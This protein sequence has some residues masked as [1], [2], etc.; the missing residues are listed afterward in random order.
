MWCGRR[1]RRGGHSACQLRKRASCGAIV[2][3]ASRVA[4]RFVRRRCRRG[5]PR[6]SR[7]AR[8]V[9]RKLVARRPRHRR[10]LCERWAPDVS[11]AVPPLAQLMRHRMQQLLAS[12]GLAARVVCENEISG[13][14][15]ARRWHSWMH[16]RCAWPWLHSWGRVAGLQAAQFSRA[17]AGTGC[18]QGG[19]C[20]MPPAS[21]SARQ[22]LHSFTEHR[23]LRHSERRIGNLMPSCHT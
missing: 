20:S 11:S 16:G 9:A 14:M 12:A 18:Q 21:R 1:G 15:R 22:P 19:G 2:L 8:S 4:R 23:L 17:I 3:A 7:A 10:R 5:P 6:P 13:R